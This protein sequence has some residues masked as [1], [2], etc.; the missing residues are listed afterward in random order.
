MV[1]KIS[2]LFGRPLH[3]RGPAFVCVSHSSA[4][5]SICM[6]LRE[7]LGTA[8]L[9]KFGVLTH[10]G[11]CSRR[12]RDKTCHFSTS[13]GALALFHHLDDKRRAPIGIIVPDI[14]A[15]SHLTHSLSHRLVPSSA[16]FTQLINSDTFYTSLNFDL[17]A[18]PTL[19][20]PGACRTC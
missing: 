7:S 15:L 6:G 1:D 14:Q 4:T 18:V 5:S 8:R 12:V 9:A 10:L 20:V 11:G 17:R 2:L 3:V 13:V 19:F 16:R